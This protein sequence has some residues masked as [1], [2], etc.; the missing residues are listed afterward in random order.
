MSI[1][2]RLLL[3][4]LAGMLAGCGNTIVV[5]RNPQTGQMAQ[6]KGFNWDQNTPSRDTEV[7]IDYYKRLGFEP[8]ELKK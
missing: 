2:S 5:L 7:C 8:V 6:C 3:I 4:A 1:V